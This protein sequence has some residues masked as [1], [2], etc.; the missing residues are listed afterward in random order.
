MFKLAKL[1][2]QRCLLGHDGPSVS[3]LLRFADA[4]LSR[5]PKGKNVQEEEHGLA[6]QYAVHMH[7]RAI[8]GIGSGTVRYL[9]RAGGE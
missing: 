1:C 4:T 8:C 9:K 2:L 7:Q 5:R 3:D 6:V